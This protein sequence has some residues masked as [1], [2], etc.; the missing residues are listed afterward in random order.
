MK[1][2]RSRSLLVVASLWWVL[3]S[4]LVAAAFSTK[5]RPIDSDES[6]PAQRGKT[7]MRRLVHRANLPATRMREWLEALRLGGPSA[8]LGAHL[9]V[10][11]PS[12]LEL[13]GTT[14]RGLRREERLLQRMRKLAEEGVNGALNSIERTAL[15][16]G[17]QSRIEELDRVASRTTYQEIPLLDGSHDV[18]LE[19]SPPH[20]IVLFHDLPDASID[21][22]GL[23]GINL[24]TATN[25][26]TSLVPLDVALDAV[27]EFRVEQKEA[28]LQLTSGF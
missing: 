3:G 21:G 17:F 14:N 7:R 11:F 16:A 1:R 4:H 19:G 18:C 28:Q 15:E 9:E 10:R 25:A 23:L 5:N 26:F 20:S 24:T 8:A 12:S 2:A 6:P 13:L 27:A 22:L